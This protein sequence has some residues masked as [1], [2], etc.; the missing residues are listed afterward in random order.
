[1]SFR[2]LPNAISLLR[3]VLVAPILLLI[4]NE[5]FPLALAL[6]FVAG[7]SD[8]IDGY[9][10]KRY[11]WH[12]RLGALLDPVADKL[13]VAGTFITLTYMHHIPIWLTAVVILRDVVIVG[14][15]A[16]YNFIVKPVQGEPT[17]IS[18]LNTA[19]QLLFLLFV[20]SRAG[21]GWPDEISITVLGAAILITVVIS[22]VDYVWSWSKRASVGE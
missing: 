19:L 5:H 3:V 8:G 20:L 14:G 21:F 18:K 9:L 1:M 2:W 10:A 11:D 12:T 6:F 17:R 16:A 22:G 13:L 4:L 7:F 15:A